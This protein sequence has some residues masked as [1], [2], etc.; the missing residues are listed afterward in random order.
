MR[1]KL[2]R[3]R[4]EQQNMDQFLS[5]GFLL[6]TRHASDHI[7][8]ELN[9]NKRIQSIC[10]KSWLR[11]SAQ[12]DGSSLSFMC[13]LASLLAF[14]SL[15]AR[16]VR[17]L[18]FPRSCASSD[19]KS[20][21]FIIYDCYFYNTISFFSVSSFPA[22][23]SCSRIRGSDIINDLQLLVM[24]CHF[25]N[26]M[27]LQTI[28]I[29]LY[30]DKFCCVDFNVVLIVVAVVIVVETPSPASQ[31][32]EKWLNSRL[33][34]HAHLNV[35]QLLVFSSALLFPNSIISWSLTWI[36]NAYIRFRM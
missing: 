30:F 14:Y 23:L 6:R 29:C 35:P 28:N 22:P 12:L 5:L 17:E 26:K 3:S 16:S 13:N 27:L 31:N 36:E 2:D 18:C 11:A 32:Q 24:F 25:D 19:F 34:D 21:H 1:I 4:L 10:E 33:H 15:H 8:G 20:F 7:K 9:R